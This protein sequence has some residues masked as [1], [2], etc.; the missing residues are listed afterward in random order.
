M[1]LSSSHFRLLAVASFIFVLFSLLIMQY[2]RIQVLEGD[3][4]ALKA[5]RQHEYIV[6]EPAERGTFYS[7]NSLK[8]GHYEEP[9]AL[10][11][12]IAKFHLYIDSLAIKEHRKEI[13]AHLV[14]LLK[15]P[16]ERQLAFLNEFKKKSRSRRVAMWIDPKTKCEILS[17]W[18]GFAKKRKIASNAIFFIADYKRSY[19]CGKLL[20]QVLHTIR[21]LKDETTHEGI[22]TG[23]L[24]AYFNDLLKGKSGKR[25]FLRSPLNPLETDEIITPARKGADIY[26]TINH[27]I[28]TIVEEELEKAAQKANAKGAWAVMMDPFTGE[29]LALGQYPF[30]D[31]SNYKA[32]FNDPELLENTK[33]K[34][35]TDAYELGSIMK[36]ITMAIAMRANEELARRGQG[37]LFNPPEMIKTTRSIF[38]GRASKPLRDNPVHGHLN[39][40][41]ALQKS[42]NVYMA[43]IVDR[44]VG[45]LGNSWYRSELVNTFGFGSKTAIELPGEASGHVP[46]PGKCFANGALEWSQ[47]TPYSLAMGH[48]LLAT[49]LQMMRAYA[50]L[51]NGGNRVT[52]TLVRKIVDREASETVLDNSSEKRVKKFP[53]ILS[54][55]TVSEIFK[56]MKYTT[57]S[58]G[59][60]VLA[61]IPGYSEG[62]K[63]GTAEKIINGTYSKNRHV[64]SFIG[65]VPASE[66]TRPRFLLLVS[67]DDPE[68]RVTPDGVR[69]HM[70]GRCAAPVFRE[71]ARRTLEYLGVEP[72]DPHGYPQGDPRFDPEKADWIKEVK[73]LKAL[74]ESYN[75]KKK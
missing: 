45:K 42:S 70:G 40:Y 51:I 28:Q 31:P 34:A 14:Q 75:S 33:V 29:I 21:E 2:F 68:F 1:K 48:S 16:K 10:A 71:I 74:Y 38:P 3:E 30:F 53:K 44:I 17:W 50:M 63:T 67:I 8:S 5:A 26:L 62:G 25:K 56:G 6:T 19:P 64:S 65:F 52:P 18:Q 15:I 43:E 73:E 61:E 7:N 39:L 27:Y 22:P 24:E 20:G 66:K 23:G 13:Q 58:G 69:H 11:I 4:W 12:D 46:E 36:P 59:T 72:D 55:A 49:S 60:A 37:P 32:F 9:Q 35:I 41:L 47:P 54:D 57:K